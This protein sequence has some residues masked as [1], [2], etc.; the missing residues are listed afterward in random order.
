MGGLWAVPMTRAAWGGWRETQGSVRPSLLLVPS[1]S[2]DS[3]RLSAASFQE[4][5]APNVAAGF[6]RLDGGEETAL[7]S[8]RGPLCGGRLFSVPELIMFC[9]LPGGRD[10]AGFDGAN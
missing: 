3:L 7:A 1:G 2:W 10:A 9:D 6:E 8:S 4:K 5:A